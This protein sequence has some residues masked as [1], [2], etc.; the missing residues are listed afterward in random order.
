MSDLNQPQSDSGGAPA[1]PPSAP[2]EP[3]SGAP[4]PAPAPSGAP[5]PQFAPEAQQLIDQ[6]RGEAEGYRKKWGP[7][8]QNFDGIHPDDLNALGG[9]A[10]ALREDPNSAV[11]WMVTNAKTLAGESWQERIMREM[12]ET[13]QQQQKPQFDPSNPDQLRELMRAEMQQVLEAR[14]TQD[15]ATQEAQRIR[16]DLE[17]AGVAENTPEWREVL[18]TM[19]EKGVPVQEAVE[20]VRGY[21][22]TEGQRYARMKAEQARRN[23]TTP[24]QGSPA[25]GSPSEQQG[26]KDPEAAAKARLDAIFGKV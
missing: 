22:E 10:R 11:D 21:F 15:R 26:P 17:K 3:N 7:I 13:A 5:A 20:E 6:L 2:A 8:A 25:P 16:S 19:K 12:G 24:P 9:L 4:A 14:T 1:A 23:P 18:H